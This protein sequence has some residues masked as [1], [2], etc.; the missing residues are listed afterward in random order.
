MAKDKATVWDRN[1]A[2][3]KSLAEQVAGYL[4]PRIR[5]TRSN[6][7]Q[8]EEAWWR[9]FNMWN[10]TKDGYHSYQGRAQL[11]IPEV[12]KN[13][14]AQARQLTKS[15]FPSEDCFN[16]S[17]G[18]T[19][20]RRG[21]QAWKSYHQWAMDQCQIKN[22]YFIAMR[23]Q[24]LLGTTPIY[25]PWRKEV[26]HEFRSRRDHKN[27]KISPVRQEVELFN[28]PDFIV[29]D[30][31]RWY[32]FNPKKNNLDDGCFE[33]MPC[34]RSELLRLS[35]DGLLANFDDIM[36]GGGNAY[37][38]E[39]F[40]R[41]VL[42]AESEGI[43]I[44]FNTASAGEATIKKDEIDS[45]FSDHT[46]MRTRVFCDMVMPEACEDG[47]DPEL[48]IPMQIDIYN[49]A[50]CGQIMR[51]QFYHQRP[52]Y[53]V[54]KYIQPNPD[55][56]YGQGIPWAIQFM[57]Y[58]LNSK[59]EQGMDSTTLSLNPIA[60]IDP[61]L[62][63][64]SNEFAVEPGA[65]WWAHPNGVKMA[66]MPDVSPLANQSIMQLKG[67]MSDYSDRSPALPPQLMGKS[68]TATQSEIVNDSMAVDNWLF[69][70]QNETLIL[71]PLLEQ[72]EAITDQNMD[73]EMLI[74]ILGRRS[75]DLKRTLLSRSDLLGRYAYQWKGAT[76][77][78]NKQITA[79]QML[80]A[81]KVAGAMPPG[82]VQM[83][84]NEFFKILWSDLWGLKDG[85]KIL[86]MP[87]EMV[88]QDADAEN[89]MVSM[90]LEIEVQP[91]D[92]DKAH[93]A[94]HDKAILE[95]KSQGEKMLLMAHILEHK[96][97]DEE[98]QMKAQQAAAAQQ[99]QM[100]MMMMQA[101]GGGKKSGAG[102]G[103]RS[104]LSPNSSTGDMA[105]GNRA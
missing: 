84:Y 30:L 59:A 62:A 15:A 66:A 9:H 44:Q 100:Q 69:Q 86:G 5:T 74:M 12:R 94:I 40:S 103:N 91:M 63:G 49:N 45:K 95:A 92:D 50:I 36:E 21:A 41:D 72:W 77:I 98:K 82:S 8:L 60:I 2:E 53:V 16:V 24:C 31:F 17:P 35:R 57:Q 46:F 7:L 88:T 29:R 58:E 22:K 61:G 42:R 71:G 26:R 25:V 14:E 43:L 55:E 83:N 89:K 76:T 67:L 10:V 80:D 73:D 18:Q 64:A 6:R 87:E 4:T 85:D 96:K 33:I 38:N 102:S 99:I 75:G 34:N 19:G 65:I 47:E 104:Q 23:Q 28:G 37:L 70:V 105:S 11:Y 51:N 54:G 81:L 1:F 68:R 52:P 79:R 39:E 56:Y 20:T 101:Q 93:M 13:V 3:N 97:A 78:A 48:P 27:K 90:G 32:V